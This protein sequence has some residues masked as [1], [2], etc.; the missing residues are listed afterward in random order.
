MKRSDGTTEVPLSHPIF[1]RVGLHIVKP[2]THHRRRRDST[3]ESRRRCAHEFATSLRRLPTDS[4]D[5]LETEHSSLTTWI[6]IDI[7]NFF[8]NDVIISSPVTNLNNSTAQEII[9]WVTTTDGCVHTADTTQLDFAVDKF[10]QTRRDCRQLVTNSVLTA[11]AT[12][13][14]S[15]LSLVVV[16]GVYWA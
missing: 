14:D 7:D 10:V 3:V 8:N 5:N 2:N 1:D 12:Q 16:G 4:V 9:N 6:L 15:M 11:D 13:L